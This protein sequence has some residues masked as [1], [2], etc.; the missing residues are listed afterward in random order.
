MK[1]AFPDNIDYNP[2]NPFSDCSEPN[3]LVFY[4]LD[5]DPFENIN[6]ADSR[7]QDVSR[8]KKRL[9]SYIPGMLLPDLDATNIVRKQ[10][11][12]LLL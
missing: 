11:I 6:L 9:D 4:D 5:L 3:H 10:A 12:K 7:P 8:L 2:E 1:R